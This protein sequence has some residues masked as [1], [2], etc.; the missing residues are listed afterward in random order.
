[1]TPATNLVFNLPADIEARSPEARAA[2]AAELRQRATALNAEADR[3]DGGWL[4]TQEAA[5]AI[6]R[7]EEN[8][9]QWVRRFGIGHFDSA[10]HRYAVSRSKLTAHMLATYGRLPHGLT[11]K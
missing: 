7:S 3:L 8:V 2:L 4:T 5:A 6:G 11:V 1:V 10:S 9:R